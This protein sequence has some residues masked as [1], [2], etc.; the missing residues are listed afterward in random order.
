MTK[1]A[2]CVM[3]KG[4]RWI[5]TPDYRLAMTEGGLG[6]TK[7]MYLWHRYFA[8]RRGSERTC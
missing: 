1:R 5:A 2:C 8:P 6:H 4:K 7:F 3:Q